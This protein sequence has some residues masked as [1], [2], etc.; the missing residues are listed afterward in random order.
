[1]KTYL[2]QDEIWLIESSTTCLRDKLLIRILSRLGCRVSEALAIKY[3][4]I[5]FHQ[6]TVSIIHLKRTIKLNCPLC[7]SPLAIKHRY[8]P[9]CATEIIQTLKKEQEKRRIRILPVDIST[10]AL[11]KEYIRNQGIDKSS[12]QRLFNISR[13]RAWQIVRDC[14]R[15]ANIPSLLNPETGKVRGISPHRLRDAFSVNAVKVDDSG[16]GLR[17]LQEHLGHANFNTTARYRKVSGD[18]HRDWYQRLWK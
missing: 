11:L 12:N 1:M 15:R 17:M 13:H 10:L 8:C 7:K 16:D 6:N 3:A 2:D 14:A 4:N 5:D 9:G 18:E